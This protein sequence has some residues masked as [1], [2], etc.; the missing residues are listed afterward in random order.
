M[1]SKRRANLQ[2]DDKTNSKEVHEEENVSDD[3]FEEFTYSDELSEVE[4]VRLENVKKNKERFEEFN[5]QK[6]KDEVAPKK[7]KIDPKVKSKIAR[8]QKTVLPRRKSVR[9]QNIQSDTN[10]KKSNAQNVFYD[11]SVGNTSS[12]K[13]PVMDMKCVNDV[14]DNE[15]K[16]VFKSW[17]DERKTKKSFNKSAKNNVNHYK[18]K[19]SSWTI[20]NICK[21]TKSRGYCIEWYPSQYKKVV[22]IGDKAGT[23]GFWDVD[24]SQQETNSV[25]MFDVHS[26][27]VSWLTFSPFDKKKLYS[28]SYDGTV[29]CGDLTRLVFN[30]KF[31][32]PDDNIRFHHISIPC[33]QRNTVLVSCSDG[34]VLTLDLSTQKIVQKFALSPNR[35]SARCIDCHPLNENLVATSSSDGTLATWDRRSIKT[36]GNKPL[37]TAKASKT[38]VKSFFSPLTGNKLLMTSQDHYISVFDVNRNGV[39]QSPTRHPIKHENYYGRWLTTFRAMWDPKTDHSFVSGS[40]AIPRRLDMFT[41]N[42]DKNKVSSY[43][44][45]DESLTFIS[46]VN[47][48]HPQL[49]IMASSNTTGKMY[50]W[51]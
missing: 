21:V 40:M 49:D 14:E 17:L 30:Q 12:R 42:E 2:L 39:V 26:S 31:V 5:F 35:I 10:V 44:L 37:S 1:K 19:I 41:C 38:I 32:E 7:I 46:S 28:C 11:A 33:K 47:V 9:I 15:L 24:R 6:A 13:P 16:T 18:D 29:T 43:N 23:I 4:L 36:K 45:K 3:E 50:L 51:S 25:Y 27:P 22:C 8:K 20:T 48:F 34:N